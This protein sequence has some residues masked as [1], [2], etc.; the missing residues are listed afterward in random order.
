MILISPEVAAGY[1]RCA[2]HNWSPERSKTWFMYQLGQDA[3]GYPAGTT[4]HEL[5]SAKGQSS[6]HRA[7]YL[8]E[9]VKLVPK[10]IAHFGKRLVNYTED[11]DGV[12]LKFADGTSAKHTVMI[13]CDGIKSRTRQIL[14]GEGKPEAF[15]Q[16]TGKY[17]Y[18]GL[19]PMEKA[20]AAIGDMQARNTQMYLGHGGHMLTF[21]VAKGATMNG[22]DNSF[23]MLSC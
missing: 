18:R 19:I 21:P 23:I 6:V 15:A 22:K 12:T 10:E 4:I 17:A 11:A 16:F 14:L 7:H 1:E 8:D 2:T 13:G 9:L 5:K 20:A 3:R